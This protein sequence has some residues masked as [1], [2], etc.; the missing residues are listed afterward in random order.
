MAEPAS[1]YIPYHDFIELYRD[2]T[3]IH[4]GFFSKVSKGNGKIVKVQYFGPN[5]AYSD[6]I[7]R[8]LTIYSRFEH[9]HLHKLLH[10]TLCYADKNFYSGVTQKKETNHVSC[11]MA[12]E[13]GASLSKFANST[14]YL[15]PPNS[16]RYA[17]E[18]ITGLRFLHKQGYL[19]GD[20]KADNILIHDE[21]AK[22]IDFGWAVRFNSQTN[23]TIQKC[24]Y[25]DPDRPQSFINSGFESRRLN[26]LFTFFS[27]SGLD[28]TLINTLSI[29]DDLSIL[30]SETDTVEGVDKLDNVID[31]KIFD[32]ETRA[33][34]FVWLAN[35]CWMYSLPFYEY[36][37]AVHIIYRLHNYFKTSIARYNRL[38]FSCSLFL[39][40][41]H[42]TEKNV[43]DICEH[44]YSLNEIRVTIGEIM[45]QLN[46][47][48]IT[49]TCYDG[50]VDL[51]DA[52]LLLL[53]TFSTYTYPRKKTEI[54]FDPEETE[55]LF[56]YGV[57]FEKLIQLDADDRRHLKLPEF[58]RNMFQSHVSFR[59]EIDIS[60]VKER[61]KITSPKRWSLC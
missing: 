43:F 20:M 6:V 60:S 7:L 38:I 27:D 14:G 58:T 35:S 8:E 40:S 32:T 52:H 59:N 41:S 44:K 26:M 36:V 16:K 33:K 4:E 9:P 57:P 29:T 45:K 23:Q 18:I 50:L 37:L 46:G 30:D 17:K 54:E 1:G 31:W 56:I 47:I 3:L 5:L 12:F 61:L 34:N 24:F 21:H 15:T 49:E 39:A 13:E 48:I 25:H 10:W 28:Q 2:L 11:Y 19:H 51:N 53:E 55:N 22:L 42:L